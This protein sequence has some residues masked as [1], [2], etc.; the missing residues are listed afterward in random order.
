MKLGITAKLFLG[1]LGTSMIVA[2]AMG[3][4]TRYNFNR[5]FIGYLNEQATERL[6]S[7]LPTAAAAYAERG[8]WEFLRNEPRNWFRLMHPRMA[9]P[10]GTDLTGFGPRTALL[11]AEQ[12]FVVGN[13]EAVNDAILRAVV[14]DGRT[15]G[16]L[17][18][19]PIQ[20]VTE[21]AALRFQQQQALTTWLI[22]ALA[23]LL[24][25]GV[26]VLIARTLLAPMRRI[27]DATHR[28]ASGDYSSR[29]EVLADDEL[30]RLSDD[31]NM[32]AQ[33]LDRNEQM[34]RV[35]MAD[36]SHELRTPLAVLRAELESMEDGVRPL[37]VDAVRDLQQSV[38]TLSKLVDDLYDLSLSDAGA[39]SYRKQNTDVMALL[40]DVLRGF[41][42][43][44]A[45][46]RI[47]ADLSLPTGKTVVHADA[48][49]LRQLFSNLIEN[50]V[51]HTDPG[52]R[53]HVL[54]E[55]A[56][57]ALIVE[58]QDSAPGVPAV[59][60]P[61]IFERFYRVEGSRNR[62]SGGAGLG[63]S[64]CRNIVDAHGGDIRA[65]SSPLGGLS[66]IV[67]LPLAA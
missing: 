38:Q 8:G 44:L 63:L 47:L 33:T 40:T 1:I 6:E 18:L 9:P 10:M 15:V 52:G 32:L 64:I 14:V 42:E 51:R 50:T 4:A 41:E 48:D 20:S 62:E 28:L 56:P 66:I 30:G 2:V 55:T 27:T 31:F 43:R 36:V 7:L 23:V 25:T 39:L 5:G 34:R 65:T 26:A 16:W 67:R 61:K 57:G 37:T 17:A 46:R 58:F 29:T 49:R 60:L 13:P 59:A 12:R 45:E 3:V 53:L 22:A 19:I 24:A 35:F 11:D 54:C 21:G